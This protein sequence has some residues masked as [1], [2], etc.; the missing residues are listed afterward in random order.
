MIHECSGDCMLDNEGLESAH[1]DYE[2]FEELNDPFYKEF[3][4][5]LS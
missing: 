3:F 4:A 2:Q 1:K 5:K